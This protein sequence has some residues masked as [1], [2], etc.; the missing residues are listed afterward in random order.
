M[1]NL[2]GVAEISVHDLARALEA[3][4]DIQVV[5][6]RAPERVLQGRIDLA[7]AG[8]FH[9]IR[10]S[11]LITFTSLVGSAIDR[12]LPVAVVCGRGNDSKVL[13]QHL[14][15]LGADARSVRGGLAAWGGLALPRELPAPST[16]DALVQFDRLAKGALGYL[17]VSD[18][19]ALVIDPPL[20][21]TAF[22]DEAARRGARIVGVADTHVHADYVSGASR[23]SRDHG[24]PYYLHPADGDYPYD[25]RAGRLVITPIADQHVI[26]VGRTTLRVGSDLTSS[27]RQAIPL[28]AE[29]LARHV[30]SLLVDG[31]W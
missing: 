18:G 23:L 29:D 24:V 4:D 2:S 22:V 5:D 12:R 25:G 8:R 6:V 28:A 16:V 11:E 21:F 7:P 30:T 9:N 15:S 26:R 14:N 3:G 1:S 19:E 31:E 20:D 27:E 13:A 10:G 17:V